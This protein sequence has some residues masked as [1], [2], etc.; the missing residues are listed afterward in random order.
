MNPPKKLI[1][2]N[3]YVN[4]ILKAFVDAYSYTLKEH[5]IPDS[6]KREIKSIIEEIIKNV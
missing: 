3:Y 4:K 2:K 5:K 1:N 6:L